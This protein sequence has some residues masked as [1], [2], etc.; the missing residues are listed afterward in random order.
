[1]FQVSLRWSECHMA[2]G[3]VLATTVVHSAPVRARCQVVS[4]GCRDFIS[5][6]RGGMDGWEHLS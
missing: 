6:F 4:G 2:A 1:M 3:K 5:V